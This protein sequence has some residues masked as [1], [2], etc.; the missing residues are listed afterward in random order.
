MIVARRQER[1]QSVD[2]KPKAASTEGHEHLVPGCW[3]LP[4]AAAQGTCG[5][6]GMLVGILKQAGEAAGANAWRDGCLMS[7]TAPGLGHR[8]FCSEAFNLHLG[9]TP[10]NPLLKLGILP[11]F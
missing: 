6:R 5:K 7:C 11:V 3:P 9:F 2:P 10:L 1:K 4:R 8:Q